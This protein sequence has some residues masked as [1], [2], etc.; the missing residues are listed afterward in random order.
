MTIMRCICSYCTKVY[1][2]KDGQGQEGDSHGI[3]ESC[4]EKEFPEYAEKINKKEEGE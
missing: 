3:C 2:Y 4:L 1:D